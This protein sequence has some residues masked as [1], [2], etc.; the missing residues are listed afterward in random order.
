MSSVRVDRTRRIAS[1]LLGWAGYGV[2]VAVLAACVIRGSEFDLRLLASA[3][4]D[5]LLRMQVDTV[6][7]DPAPRVAVI[8]TVA[9]LNPRT[10]ADDQRVDAAGFDHA[11]PAPRMFERL[12]E[13]EIE[14]IK[15]SVSERVTAAGG[16]AWYHG[17]G[18]TYRTMC[19]RLCDGAYFPISFSTSRNRFAHD[20]AVC[21]SRCAAPARLFV[22]PNPGDEPEKMVDRSGRSYIALPTA[23]Q[24]RRGMTPGCGCR[25]EAWEEASRA[26]HRQYAA[27]EAAPSAADRSEALTVDKA[28]VEQAKSAAVAPGVPLPVDVATGSTAT[29]Q[30]ASLRDHPSMRDMKPEVLSPVT[31]PPLGLKLKQVVIEAAKVPEVDAIVASEL[32]EKKRKGRVARKRV[33]PPAPSGLMSA[34]FEAFPVKADARASN[35]G[36]ITPSLITIW[37]FGPNSAAAPRGDSAREIFARNFY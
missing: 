10:S 1:T 20:E 4:D 3:I 30:T 21:A 6:E 16:D 12:E 35:A 34:L 11:R 14:R 19:V 13:A 24:F 22:M 8:A 29:L 2:A 37:G 18:R 15:A 5:T 26:K 17:S 23:F 9:G 28:E 32:G 36:S 31:T 7:S 33:Q 27:L 25:P